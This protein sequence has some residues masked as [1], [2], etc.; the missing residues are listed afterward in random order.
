[1]HRNGGA[2]FTTTKRSTRVDDNFE[3]RDRDAGFR[4][5]F[6]C[7]PK[8]P[9]P[10]ASIQGNYMAVGAVETAIWDLEAKLLRKPLWQ[11]L[12]GTKNVISCGVSIG[13]QKSTDILLEKVAR[14]V[15]SGYQRIKIKIKP[16][17]TLSSSKRFA[18]NSPQSLCRSMQI[19]RI[20]WKEIRTCCWSLMSTIC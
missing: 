10:S 15:E 14:E 4:G 2:V 13:L 6:Q 17:M 9:A 16:G 11:H 3:V 7:E 1:M 5:R 8:W 20:R 12:G 19:P 18:K